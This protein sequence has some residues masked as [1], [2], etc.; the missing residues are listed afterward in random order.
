M[1][2]ERPKRFTEQQLLAM[3]TSIAEDDSE[4]ESE[5][6]EGNTLD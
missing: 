6:K 5:N 4:G 1:I 3:L 2:S